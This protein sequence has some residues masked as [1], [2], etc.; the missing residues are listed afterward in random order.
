MSVLSLCV[1]MYL[2]LLNS[3]SLLIHSSDVGFALDGTLKVMDFGLSTIVPDSCPESDEVYNLSGE[4]GSLR[5]MAPEVAKREMYNN[6]ADVYSFGVI[7][8][9]LVA[10]TK[11]F[12]RM[13]RDE[14]YDRVVHG[15]LRPEI[16]KKFPQDLARLIQSCWDINPQVRPSFHSIYLELAEMLGSE[17]SK[18]KKDMGPN[19]NGKRGSIK[20]LGNFVKKL[21]PARQSA[22]F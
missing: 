19:N 7:L 6:K 1:L 4:T 5:Y 16:G 12:D 21:G 20:G 15:G 2:I 9:E 13:S 10:F 8:W 14:F 11:P 18:N 22:W 3:N 17:V